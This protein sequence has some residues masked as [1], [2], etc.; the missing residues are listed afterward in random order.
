MIASIYLI[1]QYTES[2]FTSVRLKC[3]HVFRNNWQSLVFNSNES[4]MINGCNLIPFADFDEFLCTNNLGSKPREPINRDLN[5]TPSVTQKAKFFWTW[6]YIRFS[7][8]FRVEQHSKKLHNKIFCNYSGFGIHWVLRVRH[9]RAFRLIQ[10][11]IHSIS[12]VGISAL[13]STVVNKFFIGSLYGDKIS[14]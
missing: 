10:Q 8:F 4:S 6:R 1:R 3:S 12:N 13:L 14:P 11:L 2:I 7:L 9:W 5:W